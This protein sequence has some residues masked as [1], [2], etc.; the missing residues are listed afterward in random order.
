MIKDIFASGFHD[1][2]F[3]ETSLQIFEYQYRNNDVYRDFSDL[4]RRN[5]D[6]VKTLKDIPFL[7]ISFFK[8]REIA[9]GDWTPEMVF[10][11]SGTTGMQSSRHFIKDLSLYERSFSEGFRYFYGAPEDYCFLAL[12]PS[13][14]ERQN[15]SLI[16]MM[17]KL[18]EQSGHPENG[19]YLYNHEE[20][21]ERLLFLDR[22][23]QKTLLWGVTYALLDFCEEQQFQLQNVVILETGGMKGKREEITREAL[24]QILKRHF[25]VAAIHSEYG[26]AELLSQAYSK[27]DGIFRTPPWMKVMIREADDPLSYCPT[28]KTGGVNIIDLANINTCSFIATQDLGKINLDHS[29]EISGRFDAADIRGCNL[30]VD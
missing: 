28:G 20:L 26:M 27:G 7:P 4:L 1:K 15:S 18:M 25:G 8:T 14:L 10:E 9:T 21:K 30:L 11:S 22:Q 5:P 19:F 24:H 12:L 13:Y 3:E 6:N 16:Y 29:F 2:D 17:E 23:G